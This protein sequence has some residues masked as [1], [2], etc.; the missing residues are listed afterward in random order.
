MTEAIVVGVINLLLLAGNFFYDRWKEKKLRDE[1][2]EK[3]ERESRESAE[4]ALVAAL[5]IFKRENEDLIDFEDRMD[6]FRR[7]M[8]M[9]EYR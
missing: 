6:E 3:I 9:R 8:R 4:K 2:N 7:E 5:K 1:M